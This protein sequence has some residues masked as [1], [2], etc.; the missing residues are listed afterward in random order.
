MFTLVSSI[1]SDILREC[2]SGNFGVDYNVQGCGIQQRANWCFCNTTHCNTH[3]PMADCPKPGIS[4]M[5]PKCIYV[6]GITN[7][8]K[9]VTYNHDSNG[10]QSKDVPPK[11]DNA[12]TSA[13][14]KTKPPATADKTKNKA[15]SEMN[16][17]MENEDMGK[18]KMEHE[19]MGKKKMKNEEM[20]KK[21]EKAVVE[22]VIEMA[23]NMAKNSPPPKS[24]LSKMNLTTTPLT[25]QDTSPTSTTPST[26]TPF[27]TTTS[28]APPDM[29]SFEQNLIENK[30]AADELDGRIT[31]ASLGLEVEASSRKMAESEL[32]RQEEA[33]DV[34]EALEMYDLLEYEFQ[35][36]NGG[37]CRCAC[38]KF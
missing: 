27:T 20:E 37:S 11:P 26:T 7:I 33:L 1:F 6:P 28:T 17:M 5:D 21:K 24:T 30:M 18:K 2:Y 16:E 22:K 34:Q 31:M 29:D 15:Q 4:N 8:T 36:K 19:D 14:N 32:A 25:T 35:N 3:I 13:T 38:T 10:S 9:P 12:N 23:K